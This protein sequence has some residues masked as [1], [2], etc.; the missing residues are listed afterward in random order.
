MKNC[1]YCEFPNP[2]E[3]VICRVCSKRM[4]SGLS[5]TFSA[6]M[7]FGLLLFPLAAIFS[8]SI[9]RGSLSIHIST[10]TLILVGAGAAAALIGALG[11]SLVD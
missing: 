11:R 6:V 4:D 2:S 3:A 5:R 10:L 7:L 1:P 8:T 9:S